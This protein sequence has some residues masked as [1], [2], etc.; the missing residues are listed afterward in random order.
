MLY[1]IGAVIVIVLLTVFL[2]KTLFHLLG[3][4]VIEIILFMLFPSLLVEFAKLV[5]YVRQ[6]F[7]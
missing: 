4:L 7:P 3:L 2:R 1:L 5:A 6:T